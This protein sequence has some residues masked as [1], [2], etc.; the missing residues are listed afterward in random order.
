VIVVGAGLTDLTCA[1]Y[2]N[3][4]GVR[5]LIYEKTPNTGGLVS[6]FSLHGIFLIKASGLLKI[7]EYCF[8]C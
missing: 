8:Q 3:K 5:A 4:N 2:M 7:Q 6:F 1:A